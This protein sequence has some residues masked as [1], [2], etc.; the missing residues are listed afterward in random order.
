MLYYIYISIL[1]F[2]VFLFLYIKIRFPFWSKQ[3]VFNVYNIYYWILQPGIINHIVN[4]KSKYIDRAHIKFRYYDTLTKKERTSLATFI[5]KNYLNKEHIHYHP[6]KQNVDAYFK[7]TVKPIY[8]FYKLKYT[9]RLIA[10]ITGRQ[11]SVELPNKQFTCYYVDYLCIHKD[12]RK[13]GYAEKMIQTH[14]YYQ[15]KNTNILVSLFKKETNLHLI[16]PLVIYKTYKFDMTLWENNVYFANNLRLIKVTKKNIY[17]YWDIIY[18]NNSFSKIIC[19]ISTLIELI[20]T[21]NIIIY[22]LK[23]ITENTP[24]AIYMFKDNVTTYMNNHIIECIGSVNTTTKALFVDGF[25]FLLKKIKQS[26]TYLFIENL[27][28][29]YLLIDKIKQKHEPVQV[30]TYAYYFYNYA[31][32]PMNNK[33]MLILC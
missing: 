15:R 8:S 19:N 26:Y 27:S 9:K 4:E 23:N 24:M 13:K 33:N 6:T 16:V 28:D 31:V 1:L 30:T 11:L 25:S 32:R 22:V 3:P 2:I 5:N 12:Y 7:H 18:K 29:N 17:D 20:E 10:C 14:E 21:N